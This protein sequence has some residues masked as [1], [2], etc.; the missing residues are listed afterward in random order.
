MIYFV[1]RISHPLKAHLILELQAPPWASLPEGR[2]GKELSSRRS[3]R[4]IKK[5]RLIFV[6]GITTAVRTRISRRELEY[7]SLDTFQ[8]GKV[9]TMMW[10]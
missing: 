7:F 6:S 2:Y 3:Y 5:A 9:K 10:E 1:R 8:T 4:E